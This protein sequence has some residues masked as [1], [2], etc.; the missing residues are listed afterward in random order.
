[1]E[2]IMH[3]QDKLSIHEKLENKAKDWEQN[4][5]YLLESAS[6]WQAVRYAR[7]QTSRGN[8]LSDLARN[9]INTS[10]IKNRADFEDTCHLKDICRGCGTSYRSENLLICV[11]CDM[12]RCG[13]CASVHKRN[14]Y[15]EP[16]CMCG[17]ILV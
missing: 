16:L 14:E 15:G 2:K 6:L 5:G 10:F 3:N 11:E 12:E 9:Y 8:N 17:G 4:N 1:M 7:S 13:G